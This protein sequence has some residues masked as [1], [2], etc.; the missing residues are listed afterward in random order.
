MFVIIV[1]KPD[2]PKDLNISGKTSTSISLTWKKQEAYRYKD[3]RFWIEYKSQYDDKWK[4]Q[5]KPASYVQE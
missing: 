4:V 5:F 3:V 2:P 1:V